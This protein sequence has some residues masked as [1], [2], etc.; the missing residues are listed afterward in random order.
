VGARIKC[1]GKGRGG[2]K[3]TIGSKRLFDQ[4]EEK[5]EGGTT[6]R[7]DIAERKKKRIRMKGG[8]KRIRKSGG[9][10]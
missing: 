1:D 10:T 7:G 3:K 8:F 2:L 9:T 5:E 4:R 6:E